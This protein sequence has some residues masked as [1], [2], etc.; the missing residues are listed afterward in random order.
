MNIL[1]PANLLWLLP[2]SG[3]IVA[4]WM[5]R[6][7]RQ[8]VTVSSLH[9]WRAVLQENQANVPFQKL[10][11]NLLLFLQ[12][13]VAFLLIF[14]L[15]RPFALGRGLS[16][17]TFVLV[18][19]TSA[20]MNATDVGPTRLAAA[21]GAAEDF[22]AHEMD[23]TD[24][25]TV[26]AAGPKP[27]TRVGFT[28]NRGSLD[29]A[30]E[31]TPGTDAVADM[32]AALTLAQS[33]AG[34]RMGA[35]I[36]VFSDGALSPDAA[37]KIAALD[38]GRT[39]VRQMPIGQLSPDNVAITA[40]DGRRNPITGRNEVFVGV[41]N[42]GGQA[43]TGGTLSLLQDGRLI[44]ARALTLPPAGQ[45]E[46]FDDASLQQGG[47]ITAR[48]DDIKDDLAA[49]NQSA[50]VLAAPRPRR[51]LLVSSGNLFLEHG[52]N[53]DPDVTL[54]EC[55]PNEYAT[56][57]KRGAGY[58]LVVFDGSL[59]SEGLPPG[60]FLVFNA[61][62]GQTPLQ[63]LNGHASNPAFVDQSRTHPVMRFVDLTGLHLKTTLKTSVQ[64]WGHT[65]AESDAG[66]LIA[67]GERDG[68]RVLSVAFDVT[69]SDW[70]LRVSF[71]IFLSN[72]AEWLTAGSRL[73]A[74]A[75]QSPTGVVAAL[76]VPPGLG[77]IS[78]ARPDGQTDAITCPAQGGTVFYDNTALAGVYHARA[79]GIDYPFAVDLLNHDESA[80]APR[81]QAALNRAGA[82]SPPVA[83]IPTA[84]RAK[85][86]LWPVLAAAAL[87]FLVVEWL[88]FHRRIA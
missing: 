2:L 88:V 58:A 76:V 11:R 9:L 23:G 51:I 74:A 7:K 83:M 80:I 43:H 50:L 44:A 18:L 29:N 21:K 20:S 52:L 26:I 27:Q 70:P 68:R 45:S 12:L 78:I 85:R 32:P 65:L 54:D 86:D 35:Q 87:A 38:F 41:Q 63:A 15:A 79:P 60:N 75:T 13:L 39:E 81:R 62:N 6:L 56:L 64:P 61:A 19:D 72:A 53:I 25:A 3:G 57:G 59:P 71:P 55:A 28:G 73:G 40:L 82:S 16:G 22:V 10:R 33:L 67:A 69:D 48:V 34:G 17:R 30:I 4:L 42:L 84:H 77:Q 24:V 14:A 31:N 36:R 47:V 1:T 5:L 49:D 37:R 66:P 46:T 8:D